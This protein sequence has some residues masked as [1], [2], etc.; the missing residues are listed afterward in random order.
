MEIPTDSENIQLVA[1]LR[2]LGLSL[3]AVASILHLGKSTI[4]ETEKWIKTEDLQAVRDILDDKVLKATVQRDLVSL[5]EVDRNI[6]VRAL[7]IDRATILVHYGREILEEDSEE[8]LKRHKED[9]AEVA[10]KVLDKLN[11]YIVWDD[12][13]L[14][15]EINLEKDDLKMIG[16][17]QDQLVIGL[18][19]H[20]KHDLPEL[21]PFSR[22]EDLRVKD[23]TFELMNKISMKA[24]RREFEDICKVCEIWKRK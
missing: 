5:E 8:E 15:G 17:F 9:L 20:L 11:T 24:A 18:F 4:V 2:V 14:I 23:I 16:F 21:A 6:L 12:N 22:W 7:Q 3:D 19:T 13:V 10:K 1:V